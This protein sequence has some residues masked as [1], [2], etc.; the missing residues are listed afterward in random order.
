MRL[1]IRKLPSI[2]ALLLGVLIVSDAV[3]AVYKMPDVS[4][5]LLG[6]IQ[7]V[8]SNYEDTFIDIGRTYNVG[9]EELKSANPGVDPWL[10]GVGTDIVLPTQFVLPE[11]ERRGIVVNVA[12]YRIYYFYTSGG[13]NYVK[14][15]PA[16]VG[17]M[18][19]S[20][21]VGRTNIVAKVRNPSWYPPESIR[22]E[23]AARGDILPKVVP[24]G[25]D[26]PLGAYA[27]RLGLSSYLIHGTNR[28]EGLGMRVTHGCVRLLPED[29]AWLFP[30][31]DLRTPVSIIN[32]PVKFGWS[33]DELYLEVHPP[34]EKSEK[35]PA[36][37]DM[38]LITRE[39][40]KVTGTK[41]A[42]VDWERVAQVYRAQSGVPVKV[43]VRIPIEAGSGTLSRNGAP[44]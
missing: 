18:D 34:L 23:H 19:W 40:V 39:Y 43:G 14:T 44:L 37:A 29:I 12:E 35:N 25:P 17:R 36:S 10:P 31:V 7:T 28:P 41:Q 22:E 20:T 27:L 6:E 24:P 15:A 11:G 21:P 16:S 13:V 8:S 4:D 5:D 3:A 9:Y 42:D 30:Q 32:Q 1:D 38:T 2:A 33:G 26:N